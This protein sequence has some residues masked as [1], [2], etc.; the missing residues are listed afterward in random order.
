MV[1]LKAQ[2]EVYLCLKLGKARSALR[3]PDRLHLPEKARQVLSAGTN[4]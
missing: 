1:F 2:A 4:P 3:R